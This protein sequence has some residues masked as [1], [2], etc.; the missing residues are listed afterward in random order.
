[1]TYNLD[2]YTT[3]ELDTLF[4]TFDDFV[5]DSYSVTSL[6][7]GKLFAGCKCFFSKLN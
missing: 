5:S 4:R 1:M 6:E 2:H 7:V 3:V